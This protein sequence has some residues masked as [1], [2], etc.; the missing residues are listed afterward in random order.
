M[1]VF[2]KNAP[3]QWLSP[4]GSSQHLREPLRLILLL[5]CASSFVATGQPAGAPET[6]GSLID[7][8]TLELSL[9]PESAR[10]TYN[11]LLQ[12]GKKEE[13]CANGL[14]FIQTDVITC[15]RTLAPAGN[16]SGDHFAC[17]LTLDLQSETTR[18]MR[19]CPEHS[20]IGV[21]N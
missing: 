5:L 3:T 2:R 12:L 15:M 13:E 19:P 6:Q 1:R 21:T 11:Q 16:T 17:H 7:E 18:S 20:I 10:G 14:R 8:R 4:S 9:D